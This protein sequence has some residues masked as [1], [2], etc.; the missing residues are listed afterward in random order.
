MQLVAVQ[1]C[2]PLIA[3]VCLHVTPMCYADITFGTKSQETRSTR[4]L[5]VFNCNSIF[6]SC[7]YMPVAYLKLSCSIQMYPCMMRRATAFGLMTLD[8]A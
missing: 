4:I 2:Q 3:G 8:S 7:L 6:C 1:P 5:E